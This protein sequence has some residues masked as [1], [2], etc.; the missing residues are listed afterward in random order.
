MFVNWMLSMMVLGRETYVLNFRRDGE[1]KKVSICRWFS[2][3]V[4]LFSGL[5]Q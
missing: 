4:Q 3:L 1:D 5:V 2:G